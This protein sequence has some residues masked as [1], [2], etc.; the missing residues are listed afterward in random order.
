VINNSRGRDRQ[1]AGPPYGLVYD[2][3]GWIAYAAGIWVMSQRQVTIAPEATFTL[4][5]RIV[6]TVAAPQGSPWGP[7]DAF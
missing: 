4:A 3:P 7:L 1:L 2:E 5:R 6:A